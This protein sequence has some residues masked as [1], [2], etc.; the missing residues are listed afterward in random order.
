MNLGGFGICGRVFSRFTLTITTTQK[1]TQPKKNP[2]HLCH[3]G[4]EEG[5]HKDLL[6]SDFWFSLRDL[7]VSFFGSPFLAVF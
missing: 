5:E 3:G 1:T 7:G 4:G 2:F 6:K